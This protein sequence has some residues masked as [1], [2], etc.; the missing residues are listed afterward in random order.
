MAA[1]PLPILHP[2]QRVTLSGPEQVDGPATFEARV[3]RD[4]PVNFQVDGPGR[5]EPAQKVSTAGVARVRYIP[6]IPGHIVTVT[7]ESEE[8]I[9][10]PLTV[11]GLTLIFDEPGGRFRNFRTCRDPFDG[12]D[13]PRTG[14]DDLR[15]SGSAQPN[16]D[17][18]Q[19]IQNA[20][21]GESILV[22]DLRRESHGFSDQAAISWFTDRDMSNVDFTDEEIEADEQARVLGLP[23]PVTIY[24]I[25]KRTEDVITEF[26]S[27][28]VTVTSRRLEPEVVE[29]LGMSSA[30]LHVRDH[31]EPRD[32]EV[33]EFLALVRSL[34]PGTWLHFHCHGG[35]GRTTTFMSMYDMMRNAHQV[36]FE[37]ILTR[38][39]LLGGI[40]LQ[41]PPPEG[42]WKRQPAIERL[43]FLREFYRYCRQQGP[44]FSRT[45]SDWK[46]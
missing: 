42:S 12:G 16:A 24:T 3:V 45:W 34:P 5:F 40:D 2:A 22:V 6:D 28:Q 19:T 39:F 8:V 18:F 30:R 36:S 9:S 43:A 11:R 27:E 1:P 13:A 7:A 37:D 23:S 4:G 14:L 29:A 25:V 20:L 44:D 46:G 38:Q 10:E 41:T 15:I 35:D 26:T 17:A 21:P 33:D 31:F 32:E